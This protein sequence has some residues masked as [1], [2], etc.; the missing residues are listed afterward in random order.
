MAQ[1]SSQRIVYIIAFALL[2]AGLAGLVISGVSKDSVY[3]LNVSEALAKGIDNLDKARL[4]GTVKAEGLHH[5]EDTVG[6]TFLLADS[7]RPEQT[8][9]VT[10]QGAV[11]DTFRPG[12]EV[13]VEG[14]PHGPH[15]GFSAHT[16]MTK[17]P[18][19]YSQ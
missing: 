14:S 18:S 5:S 8:I 11:P 6:V 12:A 4:F 10:Y 7:E 9:E 16:L 3:F 17:C 19:K 15:S 2:A 1:R 13:I